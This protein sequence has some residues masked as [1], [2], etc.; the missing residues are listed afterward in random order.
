MLLN[1]CSSGEVCH[2]NLSRLLNA[3]Q[4]SDDIIGVVL[5]SVGLL[6][7]SDADSVRSDIGA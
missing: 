5:I 7:D 2:F 1:L 4:P 6:G 3:S